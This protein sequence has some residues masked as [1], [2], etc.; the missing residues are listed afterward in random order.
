M[1]HITVTSSK[2]LPALKAL[3]A[4][5]AELAIQRL[6]AQIEGRSP[7]GV[8]ASMKFEQIG[9][10]PLDPVRPLNLIEQV[11]Q[12]FTYL[13]SLNAVEQLLEWHSE[14][15]PYRMNLGN[16]PGSDIESHDRSVIA[17]VFA[18]VR[19]SNNRKLQN[20]IQRAAETEAARKYVFFH[21]PGDHSPFE[22]RGVKVVPVRLDFDSGSGVV[23][24]PGITEGSIVCEE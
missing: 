9:A 12:C 2:E 10:D 5:A 18:S 14:A 23:N 7:L 11:N 22:E 24:H 21:A 6:Q 17:E 15:A 4:E 16:V 1:K 20:D 3:V 13:V 8:L 19:P